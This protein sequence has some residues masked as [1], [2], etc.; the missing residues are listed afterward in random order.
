MSGHIYQGPEPTTGPGGW[1][2]QMP[3]AGWQPPVP[4]ALPRKS[5]AGLWAGIAGGV[6]LLMVLCCTGGL[7]LV[8]FAN[9]DPSPG[10]RPAGGDGVLQIGV[11]LPFTGANAVMSNDTYNAMQIYLD[12]LGGV[13]GSYP[14]ALYKYD[15]S[16]AAG[17]DEQTCRRNADR[18][19][20]NKAE[21]AVIGTFNGG[22]SRTEIPILNKAGMLMVSHANTYPGLTQ[23]WDSGEPDVY[24]PSGPRNYARVFPTDEGQGDALARVVTID[25]KAKACWVVTDNT[26][27][28]N[29]VAAAFKRSANIL[30][31]HVYGPDS[32]LDKGGNYVNPFLD[33]YALYGADCIVAA[34]SFDNHGADLMRDKAA[35]WPK[36]NI[37]FLASDGF[38]ADDAFNQMPG[39]DGAILVTAGLDYGDIVKRSPNAQTLANAFKSKYGHDLNNLYALYGAQALQLVLAAIQHSDGSRESIRAQLMGGD[40]STIPHPKSILGPQVSISA[41]GDVTPQEFEVY[42]VKGGQIQAAKIITVT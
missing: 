39:A 5:R 11:D 41:K 36:S 33:P 7:L 8:R 24:Y 19:V 40:S 38:V 16:T 17:W 28:G 31:I 32:W 9:H 14:V 12:Q 27:Y 10:P 23:Q 29:G 2:G 22:C 4:P 35:F 42:Q 13:A 6:A 30:G 37:S 18:H 15:D 20:A 25:L 26:L 3:P 34:G 21:V 1:P